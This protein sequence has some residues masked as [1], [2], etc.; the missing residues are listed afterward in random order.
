V[1]KATRAKKKT[2]TET[3]RDE[4]EL[5]EKFSE[6]TRFSANTLR[7]IIFA[8]LILVDLTALCTCMCIQIYISINHR[9]I[10]TIDT[11]SAICR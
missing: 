5:S 3:K 6:C 8:F 9:G 2:V 1:G 4:P 10:E 7:L 11:L